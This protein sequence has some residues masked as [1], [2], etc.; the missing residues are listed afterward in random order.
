M[1]EVDYCIKVGDSRRSPIF[2]LIAL[3]YW[4]SLSHQR[5][6]GFPKSMI[7]VNLRAN[8]EADVEDAQT[9]VIIWFLHKGDGKQ[10]D[11]LQRGIATQSLRVGP[12][13]NPDLLAYEEMRGLDWGYDHWFEWEPLISDTKNSGLCPSISA[14]TH[15][16]LSYSFSHSLPLP[17]N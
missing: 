13:R 14:S 1:P 3:N 6:W 8:F 17:R 4:R 11:L 10:D 7:D 9:K 2:N 15:S 12:V 16:I 5:V